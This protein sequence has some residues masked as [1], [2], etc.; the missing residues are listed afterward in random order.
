M[1]ARRFRVDDLEGADL[2]V[3]QRDP[4]QARVQDVTCAPQPRPYVGGDLGARTRAWADCVHGVTV[5]AKRRVPH[6]AIAP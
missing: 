4:G 2:G 1:P 5:G 3:E 6:Q